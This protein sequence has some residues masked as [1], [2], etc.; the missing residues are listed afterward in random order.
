MSPELRSRI[1]EPFFTTKGEGEG[2]GLGL[3][4]SYGIVHAHGGTL[5]VQSAPGAGATFR[6]SLPAGGRARP[7]KHTKGS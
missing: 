3:S 6:M 4:V 5:T 1:F 2:T 7:A